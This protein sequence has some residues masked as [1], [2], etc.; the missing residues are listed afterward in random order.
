MIAPIIFFLA[1]YRQLF[2]VYI[3]LFLLGGFWLGFS[4]VQNIYVSTLTSSMG[5]GMGFGFLM[6]LMTLTNAFGPGLFGILADFTNLRM[7]ILWYTL[8]AI[9]GWLL[10]LIMAQSMKNNN[11]I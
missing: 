8:P 2:L 11:A 10:L 3:L 9:L 7:A 4:P 5:K 1:I 6:G